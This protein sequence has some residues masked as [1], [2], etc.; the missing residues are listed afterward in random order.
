MDYP[1]LTVAK[2]FVAWAAADETGEGELSNLKLQRLLYY[3]QG[4]YLA[5]HGEPLF[6]DL[7]QA[8]DCGPA[9]PSVYHEFSGHQLELAPDDPFDWD[10]IDEDTARFLMD[11]WDTYGSF[12]AWKLRNMTHGE[13][14]WMDAHQN[15][16]GGTG[17]TPSAMQRFFSSPE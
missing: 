12:A 7:I 8:W 4:R 11:I 2:W 17:I 15:G 5:K 16:E 14:P 9:V 1:A 10:A 3:A 13:S 6:A